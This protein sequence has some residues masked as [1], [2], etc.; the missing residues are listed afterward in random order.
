MFLVHSEGQE[1]YISAEGVDHEVQ[2][3]F[4][5]NQLLYHFSVFLD[6]VELVLR[7]VSG[8]YRVFP[9]NGFFFKREMPIHFLQRNHLVYHIFI[10]EVQ[11]LQALLSE[12]KVDAAVVE[13]FEKVFQPDL[14]VLE[15]GLH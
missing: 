14:F 3:W 8:E 11:E 4:F 15:R 12:L 7:H 5:Q 13:H 2:A 9:F 6:H 10:R 1:S